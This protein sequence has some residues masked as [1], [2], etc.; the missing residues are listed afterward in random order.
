M[1]NKF[2]EDLNNAKEIKVIVSKVLDYMKDNKTDL[3]NMYI[4]LF[5]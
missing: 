2:K 1:K 5:I 4:E 3:T